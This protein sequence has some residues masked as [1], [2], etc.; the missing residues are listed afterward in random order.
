MIDKN[1]EYWIGLTLDEGNIDVPYTLVSTTYTYM[2]GIY[3]INGKY[4]YCMHDLNGK[5]IPITTDSNYGDL[6]EY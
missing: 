2:S 6:H 1:K 3:G 4:H 5:A